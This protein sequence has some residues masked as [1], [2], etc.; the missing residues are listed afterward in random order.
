MAVTVDDVREALTS[1]SVEAWRAVPSRST[2]DLTVERDGCR[3]TVHVGMHWI[4]LSVA[5]ADV[6]RAPPVD[7]R[8]RLQSSARLYMAKYAVDRVGRLRRQAEIPQAGISRDHL[9]TAIGAVVDQPCR[10]NESSSA[11]GGTQVSPDFLPMDEALVMFRTL[12]ADRWIV[13]D[14]SAN[15]WYV[16]YMGPER[17]FHVYV[18]VNTAWLTFQA[19]LLA[20]ADVSTETTRGSMALAQYLLRMNDV[21]YWAKFGSTP[22]GQVLLMIDLPLAS[23][24][25]QRFRLAARTL[26]RY[27]TESAYEVQIL[28]D[29]S[30]EPDILAAVADARQEWPHV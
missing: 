12:P 27:L 4:A 23:L 8:D 5:D 13:K 9:R 10:T 3:L 14:H 28:S 25:V 1:R 22:A 21:M 11:D 19:P 7:C 16:L 6:R 2:T 17:P 18:T 15:R 29:P 30:R 24:D 20:A 26:V